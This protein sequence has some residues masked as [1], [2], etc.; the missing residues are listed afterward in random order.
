MTWENFVI[1]MQ[2]LLYVLHVSNKGKWSLDEKYLI[3][4]YGKANN[5]HSRLL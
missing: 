5:H 1:Y 4:S 3:Q 2:E